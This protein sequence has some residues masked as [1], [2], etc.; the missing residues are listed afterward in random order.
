MRSMF[1]FYLL[2]NSQN[3]I[4]QFFWFY[5]TIKI[6]VKLSKR[7]ILDSFYFSCKTGKMKKKNFLKLFFDSLEI[8][9]PLFSIVIK[10]RKTKKF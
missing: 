5:K 7:F 8:L 2:V 6:F 9:K 3:N 10:N 4:F 1:N